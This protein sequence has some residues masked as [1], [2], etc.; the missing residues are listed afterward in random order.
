MHSRLLSALS[1]TFYVHYAAVEHKLKGSQL[2]Y[3][4]LD[5]LPLFEVD[6]VDVATYDAGHDELVQLTVNCLLS[7]DETGECNT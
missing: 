4:S 3:G 1:T 5:P 2:L 7:T 6:Q